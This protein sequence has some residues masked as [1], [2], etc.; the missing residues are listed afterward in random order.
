MLEKWLARTFCCT[1]LLAPLISAS[2]IFLL[3][4]VD[5]KQQEGQGAYQYFTIK[6]AHSMNISILTFF[7][8]TQAA[9]PFLR[10]QV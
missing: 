9:F 7:S 8:I 2:K 5:T 6:P 1:V 4:E 10:N 3:Y